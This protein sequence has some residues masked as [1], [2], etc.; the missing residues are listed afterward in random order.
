MARLKTSSKGPKVISWF[1]IF[2][3]EIYL[4]GTFLLSLIIPQIIEAENVLLLVLFLSA[5]YISLY[6]GYRHG[7]RQ[8]GVRIV[9]GR[10][11]AKEFAMM[12]RLFIASAMYFIAYGL[13]LLAEYGGLSLT[14]ILTSL[15][16]PGYAYANKFLVYERQST[17]GTTNLA[18]Q[19]LVL[20]SVFSTFLI[21]YTILLWKKLRLAKKALAGFGLVIYLSFFLFTGTISGIGHLCICGIATYVCKTLGSWNLTEPRRRMRR[22]W[23]KAIL[24]L[25][26]VILLVS[27]V[28]YS[29]IQRTDVFG[30]NKKY[31]PMVVD[32]LAASVLGEDIALGFYMASTY[33]TQGYIGLSKNL[34]TP[35]EWTYGLGSSLA[36]NS[37]FQQY[38][39]TGDMFPMTYPARTE[40]RTGWPSLMYW[41]TVF[42][43]LASDMTFPG[44]ILFMFLAGYF[45]ARTWLEAA[46]RCD[47]VAVV[48]F[49]QIVLFIVFIPANNQ[50][51]QGRAGLWS[52]ISL[53][54]WYFLTARRRQRSHALSQVYA[55]PPGPDHGQLSAFVREPR[56][57][58]RQ[59]LTESASSAMGTSRDQGEFKSH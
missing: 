11:N 44:T 16:N 5:A 23:K 40:V 39:G 17:K 3:A 4:F 36:L 7:I 59:H 14:A 22:L 56:P 32:S 20:L 26:P 18:I 42:P 35:F 25:L 37:Y 27:Y 43:W 46:V 51:L 15:Q 21:P 45:L 19:I 33:T 1:P 34:Q 28:T 8:L 29:Q 49:S 50:L 57:V 58:S 47:P 30:T 2:I 10:I 38:L 41:T 55:S 52:T 24:L 31:M 6:L 48:I 54:T 13:A 9:A 12:N 53:L